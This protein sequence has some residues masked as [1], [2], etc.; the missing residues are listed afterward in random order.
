MQPRE[1]Q[2]IRDNPNLG[3]AVLARL[4]GCGEATVRKARQSLGLSPKWSY[5]GVGIPFTCQGMRTCGW[6]F[7]V[8]K[9]RRTLFQGNAK[10]MWLAVDRLIFCLENNNGRLPSSDPYYL[11]N[12]EFAKR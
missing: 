10:G 8:T 1:I 4:L 5:K 12:L 11:V 3:H 9:D 7:T 6:Y 2:L